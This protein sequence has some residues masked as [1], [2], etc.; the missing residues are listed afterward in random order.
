MERRIEGEYVHMM[1]PTFNVAF[2]ASFGGAVNRISAS[3]WP[4]VHTLNCD[5][6]RQFSRL[7]SIVSSVYE[8]DD[9]VCS[10]IA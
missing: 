9:R 5:D 6:R 2:P 3:S 1:F 10:I 8:L 7:T 4:L